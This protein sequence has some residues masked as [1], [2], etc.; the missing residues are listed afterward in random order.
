MW[1]IIPVKR[2]D[3]SKSRLDSVLT[4]VQRQRFSLYMLQDIL[5]TLMQSVVLSG[6]TVVSCDAQVM[7]LARAEGADVLNSHADAGY[8]ADVL[9]GVEYVGAEISANTLIVPADVPE[10]D[11][12]ALV[13]LNRVH[14]SGVTLCPASNDGGTNGLVFTPPLAIDLMYGENSFEKFRLEAERRHTPVNIARP[15]GLTRD[16]DRPDDLLALRSQPN[17]GRAWRFLRNLQTL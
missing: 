7:A 8:A 13:Y 1:V 6:V 11:E 9:K 2:L 15:A 3:T 16:I 4:P 12:S 5:H 10:L 14:K 17:G